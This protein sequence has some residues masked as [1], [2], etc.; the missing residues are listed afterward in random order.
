MKEKLV[1]GFLAILFI[2]SIVVAVMSTLRAPDQTVSRGLPLFVGPKGFGVVYLYGHI[3]SSQ[4]SGFGAR[5]GADSVAARLRSVAANPQVK[6]IVLRINSPGGSVAASQELYEEV[7]RLR[8]YKPIVASVSD[9]GAS[10]GYYVACGSDKIFANPGSIVGS[11]GVIS[12][13]PNIDGLLQGKLGIKT[14][15]LTSGAMKDAGSPLRDMTPNEEEYFRKELSKVYDQFF[16]AVK[17]SRLNAIKEK[18][19]DPSDVAAAPITDEQAVEKLRTL[20]DGRVFLGEEARSEGLIDV[21]GNFHDAVQEAKKLGNLPEDAPEITQPFGLED[22]L[23]MVSDPL[24]SSRSEGKLAET[25][26]QVIKDMTSVRVEYLYL[27]G[28]LLK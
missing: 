1:V 21:L 9:L 6:A 7:V 28:G 12:I 15:V 27:P 17:A 20:A 13:F 24:I 19:R 14:K 16:A 11:I 22:L 5:R 8:K 26:T 2:A 18:M 10:G 4:E 25:T 23:E 3:E